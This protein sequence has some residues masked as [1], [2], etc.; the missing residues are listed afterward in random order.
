V[1]EAL[2]YWCMRPWATSAR[3]LKLIVYALQRPGLVAVEE[4]CNPK[5]SQLTPYATS[6]GGLELIV[7][8]AL[9]Y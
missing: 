3:G 4:A 8:A 2:S 9:S 6:V 5:P 7:Y 1:Y